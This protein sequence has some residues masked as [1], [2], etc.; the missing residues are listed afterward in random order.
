MKKKLTLLIAGPLAPPAGGVSIHIDRLSSLLQNDFFI[1]YIDEASK[2]K[3][4]YFN[5]RSGNLFTYLRKIAACDV[6]HIHTGNRLLKKIHLVTGRLMGKKIIVTIHGFGKK[7]TAIGFYIDSLFY[8]LAN[9]IILVN[10]DIKKQLTIPESKCIYQHAFLPPKLEQEDPLPEEILEFI[11]RAKA[12]GN[13]LLCANASRLNMH[14][15]Q[16]LYGLDMC[17][18]LLKDL[19]NEGRSVSLIFVLSNESNNKVLLGKY[20][21]EV[22]DAALEDKFLL[23][24]Q[25][26]S[27][28]RLIEACDA[29]LRP[30][31][32][33]GDAL[34]VR[35]ALFL[36]KKVIASDIVERPAGTALFKTR[37]RTDLA[38]VTAH[39]LDE[40][41]RNG[42]K[43]SYTANTD[44]YKSFYKTLITE[45]ASA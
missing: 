30:T 9:K 8:R 2:L 17:I 4:A 15:G 38:K 34:T 6:F 41:H 24:R 16:D 42:G 37:D 23:V 14:K 10:P 5:I 29:V 26:I 18:E 25:N 45:L 35:E 28:I 32:T 40:L 3:P 44:S 39:K 20:M 1:D 33:D 27:F 21:Q 31:N 22:H 36:G 12:S 19:N 43:E 7:R 13:D 11:K